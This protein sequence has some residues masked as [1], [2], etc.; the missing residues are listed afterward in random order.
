[1]KNKTRNIYPGGNTPYGFY[2]YYNY[3]LPQSE[4]KKI[5]CIKGGPGSGKSTMMKRIGEYFA[6]RNEKVDFLWCSS[7]PA[8]LDGILLRNRGIA[9]V[10]G[11]APHIVDPENPGAVD[12]IV[13]MGEYWDEKGIRENKDEIMECNQRIKT[14]FDYAY[15]YLRCAGQ[16]YSFM[17]EIIDKRITYEEIRECQNQI[18]I[19]LDSVTALKR[20]ENRVKKDMIMGRDEAAGKVR[21]FFASAITPEGIISHIDSIVSDIDKVIILE[22]PKGFRTEK[23]LG[24]VSQRLRDAGFDVEEYYC[25]MM[26][27]KKIE[28]L[29]CQE[30]GVAVTCAN[31]YHFTDPE[32]IRGKAMEIKLDLYEGE[33]HDKIS[34]KILSHLESSSRENISKAVEILKSAKKNHDVL[35]SY[36]ISNMDFG[37]IEVLKRRIIS[38][39]EKEI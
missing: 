28:H 18:R 16:Q 9:I 11:T 34:D 24:P 23:L 26:P 17:S 36:Y 2:S 5:F 3:I 25:P 31:E 20:A 22:V 14:L 6:A 19:K 8:S 4:A 32:N 10:D 12:V 27:D 38:S 37:K 39:V 35:E 30:A 7:D 21:R 15:G 33:P 29:V 13:N 1:M